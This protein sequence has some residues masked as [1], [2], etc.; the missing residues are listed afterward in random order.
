MIKRL[1]QMLV[2]AERYYDT[3]PEAYVR[4]HMSVHC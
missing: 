4:V 2:D 1:W 3:H